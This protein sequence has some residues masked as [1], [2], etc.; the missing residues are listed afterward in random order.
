M[1]QKVTT[2]QL[3]QRKSLPLE[4]KIQMSKLRIRQWHEYWDGDVC[5]SFSG[6]MDSTVL[7]HLVRSEYPN[8]PAIFI[9]D[10]PYP[11]IKEHV[12]RTDNVMIIRPQ[13]RFPQVIAE[14]GYP[15][16]S[17]RTA[18]YIHEVRSAKGD[19]PTKR[20]RLTGIKSNGEFSKLSMIPHKWQY[21][22]GAPF[23]IS[24]RCCH[25][26]KK[27]P[28]R[29]ARKEFGYPFVGTRVEE[30]QQREQ[31]YLL[32][33]CNAFDI[34]HPRSMPLAFWTDSD[35]WEYVRCFDVPYSGIY[36]MGYKRTGCFACMFGVHLE[37]EP[38]RFQRMQV[39]HP[40]LWQYCKAIGVPEV[41]DYIGVPYALR[42]LPLFEYSA[43]GLLISTFNGTMAEEETCEPI[44]R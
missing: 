32:Y 15:I 11:E 42:Q 28:L 25:W 24:N 20:L 9:D 33:G 8:V 7:L 13:K 21:L 30:A 37:A 40:K 14:Y 22:C 26:L 23:K 17:K 29:E 44:A 2:L 36:D 27:K 1:K 31:A 18:Q 4:A 43:S 38:N 10:L 34:S 16:I 3:R 39:T 35:I 5:V 19:T 12:K 6:G 41:L